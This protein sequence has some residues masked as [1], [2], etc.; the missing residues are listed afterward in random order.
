MVGRACYVGIVPPNE[1]GVLNKGIALET[2]S[3]GWLDFRHSNTGRYKKISKLC[4]NYHTAIIRYRTGLFFRGWFNNE[5]I[6]LERNTDHRG[7]GLLKRITNFIFW[8]IASQQ[9]DH[10]ITPTNSLSQKYCGTTIPNWVGELKKGCAKFDGETL[11]MV[12]VSTNIPEWAGVD[13]LCGAMSAYPGKV[14]LDL[15]IVGATKDFSLEYRIHEYYKTNKDISINFIGFKTGEKLDRVF[16]ESN[17]AIGNLN[18]SGSHSSLKNR[19]YCARA[20]PFIYSGYDAQFE[21]MPWCKRVDEISIADIILFVS[22]VNTSTMASYA[23]RYLSAKNTICDL[24][25]IINGIQANK[26]RV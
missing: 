24:K 22:E 9:V 23:S 16:K 5:V 11:K 13:K 25:R 2:A 12:M 18:V 1:Y 15:T 19:E 10:V 6:I 8:F 26:N 20:I 7:V 21:D 3:G 14:K 17:L 4:R